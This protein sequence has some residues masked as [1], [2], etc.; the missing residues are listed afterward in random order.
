MVGTYCPGVETPGY[1]LP[2]L[3]DLSCIFSTFK[4]SFP[5]ILWNI[6]ENYGMAMAFFCNHP[7][8][9]QRLVSPW[10][11]PSF[12]RELNIALPVL[13]RLSQK[14]HRGVR[15]P[16]R[17]FNPGDYVHPTRKKSRRDAGQKLLQRGC[18][19]P[20]LRFCNSPVMDFI[21]ALSPRV[22]SGTSTFFPQVHCPLS[23]R[24]DYS[25]GKHCNPC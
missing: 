20:F 15:N 17:G 19:S 22:F 16:V 21:Y 2:S 3:R 11:F 13:H 6:Y 1:I 10:H 8:G 7:V 5:I 18:I 4:Q 14:P 25:I 23:R 12:P 24:Q 9:L